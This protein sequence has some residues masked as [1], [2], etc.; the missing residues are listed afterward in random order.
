MQHGEQYDGGHGE[1]R[2]TIEYTANKIVQAFVRIILALTKQDGV[3]CFIENEKGSDVP[4]KKEFR[5]ET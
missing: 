4:D 2:Q 1:Y 3:L 5:F